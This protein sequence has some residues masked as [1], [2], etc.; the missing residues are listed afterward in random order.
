VSILKSPDQPPQ[1][2]CGEHPLFAPHHPPF[3]LPRGLTRND[4]TLLSFHSAELDGAHM[5]SEQPF[6]WILLRRSVR[7]A[8]RPER[9][10]LWL[11]QIPFLLHAAADS[12]ASHLRQHNF[13][14][15]TLAP[16]RGVCSLGRVGTRERACGAP[17]L[18]SVRDSYGDAYPVW[19][20]RPERP[21][22]QRPPFAAGDMR[23]RLPTRPKYS[24]P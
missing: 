19:H 10:E 3:G 16:V 11:G 6:R 1:P 9:R 8:H 22:R 13:V 7:S 21:Y 5:V 14:V 4:G 2:S 18:G 23:V 20:A 24:M 17:P 12:D 15:R